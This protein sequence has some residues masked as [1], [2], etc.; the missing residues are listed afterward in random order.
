M[1]KWFTTSNVIFSGSVLFA[2]VVMGKVY[3][4]RSRLPADVCPID[5]NATILYIGIGVLVIGIIITS[6]LDYRNK[7][8]K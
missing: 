7:N 4:D 5:H 1:K 3:Y 2:L 8:R 6:I